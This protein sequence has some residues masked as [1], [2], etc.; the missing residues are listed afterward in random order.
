MLLI[1]FILRLLH[2]FTNDKPNIVIFQPTPDKY[3]C[4]CGTESVL[5]GSFDNFEHLLELPD[6]WYLSDSEEGPE[7]VNARTITT[8]SPKKS[9]DRFP[10]F[11]VFCK[12]LATRFCMP[13]WTLEEISDCRKKIFPNLNENAVSELFHKVGGVP[14][15]V[16]FVPSRDP[17]RAIITGLGRIESA[18]KSING[19]VET[20]HG[21]NENR[22]TIQF[23]T[24]LLHLIPKLLAYLLEDWV[25]LG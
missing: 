10:K 9:H 16:L 12:D 11:H 2:E 8:L 23:S 4:Y 3:Y 1:Y 21:F 17:Q 6:V 24:Q 20:S 13:L 7:T 18:L 25:C 19:P 22:E 5:V 14:R 15:N